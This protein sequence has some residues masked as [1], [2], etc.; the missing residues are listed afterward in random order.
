MAGQFLQE[1]CKGGIQKLITPL[2][3]AAMFERVAVEYFLG[4]TATGFTPTAPLPPQAPLAR[5]VTPGKLHRGFRVP[6]E[7]ADHSLHI[8]VPLIKFKWIFSIC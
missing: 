8:L 7:V 4:P 1:D 3:I 2:R 6:A 5:P